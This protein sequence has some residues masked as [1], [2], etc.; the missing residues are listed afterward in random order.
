M[1][2]ELERVALTAASRGAAPERAG[3]APLVPASDLE[4]GEELRRLYSRFRRR[5]PSIITG[6]LLVLGAV[7]A[8]T[9]VWPRTYQSAALI[10]IEQ[11][12]GNDDARLALLGQLGRATQ[13][14]T[15]IE[16]IKSRHVMEHVVDQLDLHATL[17]P[18]DSTLT[19][20]PAWAADAVAQ[21]RRSQLPPGSVFPHFK[22]TAD[23]APGL[24]RITVPSP[25]RI[26]VEDAVTHQTIAPAGPDSTAPLTGGEPA[27]TYRF[28]GVA[29]SAPDSAPPWPAFLLRVIPFADAVRETLARVSVAREEREA[30]LIEVKCEDRSPDGA[31]Q[32]CQTVVDNYVQLRTEMRRAEAGATATFL[33]GQSELLDQHLAAAEDSL[34]AYRSR[35]HVVALGERAA[36]EVRQSTDLLAQ[37]DQL[38]AQRTALSG[39]IDQIQSGGGGTRR[40]RDLASFPTFLQN[41]AVTQLLA[42]LVTL[43]NERGEL[44]LRRAE[45]S[46]EVTALD[47]RISGMEQQILSIAQSYRRALDEQIGS[48]DGA[49][50]SA[51]GRLAE[52]PARQVESGRLERQVSLLT[53]I[54]GLLKTRLREAE[55]A[56]AV[57]LP[58]VRVVDQ[59][60]LPERPAHPRLRINLLFGTVLGLSF[61]LL[62]AVYREGTDS[63]VCER[64]DVERDFALPV[65]AMIPHIS[66]P[67]SVLPVPTLRRPDD[68]VHLLAGLR[69]SSRRDS[70]NR[71]IAR[72]VFRSFAMDLWFT[73]RD[74]KDEGTVVAVTSAGRG[75]GKTFVACNLALARVS[76]GAR[77]LLIDADVRGGG[78]TKFFGLQSSLPG[79]SDILQGDPASHG[80]GEDGVWQRRVW[81]GLMNQAQLWVIPPGTTSVISARFAEFTALLQQ[82]KSRFD[83]IV[84]DTPPMNL[85]AD[86]APIAAVA[87]AV[88][89][90][91]RGS[92]TP[93]GSLKLTLDRLGR[94]RSFVIGAVLNDVKAPR[95]SEEAYEYAET[96]EVPV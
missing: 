85:A 35:N 37:R 68:E 38:V 42:S 91:A 71:L 65:L 39:F 86:T 56:E 81:V 7:T 27:A 76:Q 95:H 40:Y 21:F 15:E 73:T 5:M 18:F 79:L 34:E 69:R 13:I 50:R 84:I 89:V 93:R 83:L 25:G 60:S 57:N 33:R 48:L 59:A 88:L 6:M 62:L 90:V 28:A 52:I 80:E 32:L 74:Q 64:A 17:Q 20:F 24:Y 14:E 46:T 78:A 41:Q 55:V 44:L 45:T 54:S 9:L 29:L 10:V 82:F 58:N 47:E 87:D 72:Q 61:G 12:T 22:A 31:R 49:L 70:K 16:L 11:P 36:E 19:S 26:V 66:G 53:D 51:G 94:T 1:R 8:F 2:N 23:A 92:V 4:P 67:V 43:E 77:T 63:R 30:D 75:E 3:T 96:E